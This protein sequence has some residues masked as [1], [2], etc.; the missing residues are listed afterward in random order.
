MI[1]FKLIDDKDS[2]FALLLEKDFDS[3]QETC[4]C[5]HYC[6]RSRAGGYRGF[7][8]RTAGRPRFR[9]TLRHTEPQYAVG[10]GKPLPLSQN[11]P[12]DNLLL[13]V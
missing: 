13:Q 8:R 12:L 7:R 5:G 10:R 2:F 6:P 3:R 9:M 11:L 4:L 1:L